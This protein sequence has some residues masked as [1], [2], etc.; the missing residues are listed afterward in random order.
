MRDTDELME[1][2]EKHLESG[3]DALW[4]SLT[5]EERGVVFP[6]LISEYVEVNFGVG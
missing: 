1:L 4:D 2:V 6:K 3:V 5:P